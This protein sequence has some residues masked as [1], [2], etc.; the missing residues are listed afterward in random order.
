MRIWCGNGQTYG[1]SFDLDVV[2]K[3]CERLN[4]E[5]KCENIRY[6]IHETN[7]II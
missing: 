2:T 7:R 4:K 6:S 3:E 1:Y 5:N